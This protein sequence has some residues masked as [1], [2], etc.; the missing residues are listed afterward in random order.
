MSRQGT[1]HG[2]WLTVNKKLM[3]TI[4]RSQGNEYYEKKK[5]TTCVNLEVNPSQPSL[6]SGQHVDCNQ[7]K[8]SKTEDP[9]KL[10]L[11]SR[12]RDNIC[13]SLKAITFRGN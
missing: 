10:C 4:Q 2:L 1:E 3:S 8:A 7:V 6:S 11:D 5:N 13:E 12:L 9:S